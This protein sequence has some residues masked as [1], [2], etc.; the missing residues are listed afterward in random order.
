MDVKQIMLPLKVATA[1][2]L[3]EIESGR[4]QCW[5]PWKANLANKKGSLN[6]LATFMLLKTK[7]FFLVT[8]GVWGGGNWMLLSSQSQSK[9][10]L[11]GGKKIFFTFLTFASKFIN[12]HSLAVIQGMGLMHETR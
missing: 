10:G 8:C 1:S 7:G 3:N 6:F 9:I 2:L 12:L 5:D 11:G 4:L